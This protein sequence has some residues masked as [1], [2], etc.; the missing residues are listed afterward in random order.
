MLGRVDNA[1]AMPHHLTSTAARTVLGQLAC[2]Q[3]QTLGGW[4]SDSGSSGRNPPIIERYQAPRRPCFDWLLP[5][6]SI[7]SFTLHSA[8]NLEACP[9][10]QISAPPSQSLSDLRVSTIEFGTDPTV[11]GGSS[12]RRKKIEPKEPSLSPCGLSSRF[13]RLREAF[14][15]CLLDEDPPSQRGDVLN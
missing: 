11:S 7:F 1:V 10:R 14:L 9:D 4:G 12:G 13:I 8:Q 6:H 5:C 15:V 2:H 3:R